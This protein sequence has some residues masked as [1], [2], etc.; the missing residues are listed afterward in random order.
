VKIELWW[1]LANRYRFQ[2]KS[3]SGDLSPWVD[4]TNSDDPGGAFANHG[5]Y[6]LHFVE[7]HPDNG[8][9]KLTI[10]TN[11]GV[12]LR[13]TEWEL[14]IEALKVPAEG[15]IHAWIERSGY[16]ATEFVNHDSEEMTLS[17]PGTAHNVITV[18][19]I[20]ANKP[21]RV[22]TF[23]S[24]GPTRDKR[25]NPKP[26]IAAPGVQVQAA[27]RGTARD[28]IAMDGTSM[29]APHVTGAI[30]LVLSKMAR[31]G[32]PIPAATQIGAVLRQ[33]TLNYSSRWDRG[34]GYGVL[35]V[36]GLLDA[37]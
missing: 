27:R 12:S 10:E 16:A 31:A 11:D 36:A 20:D 33:K 21:V 6:K 30:A 24:Y 22:G 23:S 14:D 28:V 26:D 7:N 32:K 34:Q 17:I 1:P 4:R 25:D 19:A 13:Q 15:D 2:L 8:D 18:G 35:D 3:P 5:P 37:F 9:S 29:A